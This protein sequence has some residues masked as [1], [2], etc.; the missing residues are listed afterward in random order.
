MTLKHRTK[1]TFIHKKENTNKWQN[2]HVCGHRAAHIKIIPHEQSKGEQHVVDQL[3]AQYLNSTELICQLSLLQLFACN[4][5]T[6]FISRRSHSAP[7]SLPPATFPL[8]QTHELPF[9]SCQPDALWLSLPRPPAHLFPLSSSA[10]HD[11]GCIW[12]LRDRWGWQMQWSPVLK[13]DVLLTHPS[14]PSFHCC[15]VYFLIVIVCYSWNQWAKLQLESL[16]KERQLTQT[17]L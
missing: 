16:R 8:P 4:H 10:L 13:S 2:C 7:R 14:F 3:G 12:I 17:Q 9:P 11:T 6:E 5:F 15:E 1:I